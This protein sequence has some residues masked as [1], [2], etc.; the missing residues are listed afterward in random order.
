VEKKMKKCATYKKE[1]EETEFN[2]RYKALGMRHPT[3]REC[4]HKFNKT[5]FESDAKEKH[6]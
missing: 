1:K 4:M 3:C 2:W 5:Y 6:L